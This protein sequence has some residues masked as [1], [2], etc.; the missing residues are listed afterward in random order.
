MRRDP[1]DTKRAVLAMLKDPEWSKW[2]DRKIAQ[3]VHVHHSTV[4]EMRKILTVGTDSENQGERTY[5]T[6]HGTI[7]TMKVGNIGKRATA[8]PPDPEFDNPSEGDQ[9]DDPP[10]HPPSGRA[11]AKPV[12]KVNVHARS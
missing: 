3:I 5:L 10:T 12:E 2:S 6:K 7:A 1:E 4:S 11:S 9:P 8:A